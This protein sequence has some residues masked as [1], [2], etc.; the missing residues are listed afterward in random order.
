MSFEPLSFKIDSV[1]VP[2]CGML[3]DV[4]SGNSIN[5]STSWINSSLNWETGVEAEDLVESR[6]SL[7]ESVDDDKRLNEATIKNELK[8]CT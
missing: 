1:G 8:L 6:K 5:C 2:N 4:V 7:R 3:S